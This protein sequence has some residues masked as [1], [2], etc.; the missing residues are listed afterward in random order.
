MNMMNPHAMPNKIIKRGE[1]RYLNTIYLPTWCTTHFGTPSRK[2]LLRS[3]ISNKI[4]FVSGCIPS[5][6]FGT[7]SRVGPG[8]H[9]RS[10]G[11][12]LHRLINPEC[13]SY[14]ICSAAAYQTRKIS[15]RSEVKRSVTNVVI[16]PLQMFGGLIE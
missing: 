4:D 12:P 5:F 15:A 7:Q 10:F 11:N 2:N 14:R 1:C 16:M 9:I 8:P 6:H 3:S 13:S